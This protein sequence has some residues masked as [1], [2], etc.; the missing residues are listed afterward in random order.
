MLMGWQKE[1]ALILSGMDL[2]VLTSLWEG[3]PIVVLEAMAARVALVATN[4]G[5]IREV[6]TNGQAG[7]LVAPGDILAMHS[8]VK[9]L[10]SSPPKRSEFADQAKSIIESEEFSLKSVFK[11]TADLYSSLLVESE[12]A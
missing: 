1:I 10:L 12:N 6:I 5:G 8:R 11:N 9:E 3:L 2:F 4:T 7:Y